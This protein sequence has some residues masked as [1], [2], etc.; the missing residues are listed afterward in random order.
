M[1]KKIILFAL[2][3]F[4]S[5]IASSVKATTDETGGI[6]SNDYFAGYPYASPITAS[7]S[8]TLQTIGVNVASGGT[9]HI[10]VAIYNDNS[11]TPNNLLCESGS[12]ALSGTGWIDVDVS[13]CSLSITTST[14]YWLALQS[15]TVSDRFYISAESAYQTAQS[16]GAFPN[17][18]GGTTAGSRPNMRMT[19]EIPTTTTTTST[20]TTTT[21]P[22]VPTVDTYSDNFDNTN[23]WESCSPFTSNY[24]NNPLASF[25]LNPAGVFNVY[26]SA[27]GQARGVET[28]TTLGI[29]VFS[30]YT[31]FVDVQVNGTTQTYVRL[32]KDYLGNV[33][34]EDIILSFYS[35]QI[36]TPCGYKNFNF[37][38]GAWY[39]LIYTNNNTHIWLYLNDTVLCNAIVYSVLTPITTIVF[40]TG[41][42]YTIV[43][44]LVLN[45]LT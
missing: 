10:R 2:V 44:N 11:N 18:F 25:S 30:P 32:V 13:S 27:S 12:T 45:H 34:A 23:N 4:L 3:V 28:K 1:N 29:Q 7:A 16:Y 14:N 42:N 38:Y 17:P 9:G 15:D 43:D 8:G 21:T 35:N 5:F 40:L 20:P 24:C 36:I 22:A 37:I 26:H 39:R 19:Y 31:L 33:A 6:S 41:P